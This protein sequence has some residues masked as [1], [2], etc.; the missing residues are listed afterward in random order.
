MLP[1]AFYSLLLNLSFIHQILPLSN[2]KLPSPV[3]LTKICSS[4][5]IQEWQNQPSNSEKEIQILDST[6]QLAR[7][8]IELFY[9]FYKK[10]CTN[11]ASF[12]ANISLL[13]RGS[14][15]RELNDLKFRFVSRKTETDENGKPYPLLGFFDFQTKHLF[16]LNDFQ[17][18]KFK[19][20]WAHELF[21]AMNYHCG[22]YL[23]S[24]A[25]ERE[26]QQFTI[27]LGLGI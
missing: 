4:I 9:S 13:N 2:E 26:A 7:T 16:V 27:F 20:I 17:H 25:E 23:N 21:H 6:C 14:N 1:I 10:K 11:L 12:Q 22:F 8:K 3:N 19:T 24:Q 15:I 18:S 5:Q